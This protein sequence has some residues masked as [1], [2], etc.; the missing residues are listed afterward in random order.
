MRRIFSRGKLSVADVNILMGV[1]RQTRW[2]IQHPEKK[3]E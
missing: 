2:R 1:A 3:P